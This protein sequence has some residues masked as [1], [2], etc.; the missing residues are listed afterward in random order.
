MAE[1]IHIGTSGWSYKHW[2]DIFYPPKMRPKDYLS[3]YANHFGTAEINAS[4]YRLPQPQTVEDWSR[5]VPDDFKFCPK[6][7]RYLSHMKKLRDP[8]EP[9]QRFFGIFEPMKKMLGPI[10]VQLPVQATFNV[11]V[12][13]P[14]FELL[15]DT[16]RQY[17]FVLEPRHPSW[18]EKE[19]LLLMTRFNIGLVISQSGVSFPYSELN[20]ASHFYLRFHGPADL[21]ASSYTDEALK[22]F[23][24]KMKN[25]EKEGNSVW[26]F[27]NNDIHGHAF[28][29]AARLAEMVGLKKR[30]V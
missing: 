18:F 1:N 15:G 8:G 29:D 5:H 20:T 6:M 7:S 3:F 22:A 26:A 17:D 2:R 11:S 16:Y 19:P 12:C 28:R 23:A 9:L 30:A 10:L 4:F 14:F 27:F 21:Y 24:K 13:Q 25:W